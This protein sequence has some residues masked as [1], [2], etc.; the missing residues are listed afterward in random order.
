MIGIGRPDT[1]K[2]A[3]MSYRGDVLN[4]S[5]SVGA[6]YDAKWVR[7]R[8][9]SSRNLAMSLVGAL[10]KKQLYSLLNCEAL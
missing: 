8:V 2:G 4:T 1:K 3:R 6:T 7:S 9:K 10:Q 5:P